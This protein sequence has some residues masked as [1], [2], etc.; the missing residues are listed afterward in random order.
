MTPTERTLVAAAALAVLLAV[1]ACES[2]P[3]GRIEGSG[4]IEV[5]E[6]RV[7]SLVGG[8]IAEVLVREGDRVSTGD[9]LLR[10]DP[11]DIDLQ[12]DQARAGLKAAEAQLAMA[13]AGA[14][15][16]DIKAAKELV[17]QASAAEAS[18]TA[19]LERVKA[20]NSQGAA[21]DKQRDDAQTRHDLAAAQKGQA[22]AQYSKAAGGAR[23]EELE[24]AEAGVE[25]ARAAVNL[26]EKKLA[27]CQVLAPL[28]GVVV[29]RLVEPGEIGGPGGTLFVI[30]DHSVVRLT[31]FIPETDLGR[32]TLGDPVAVSIDSHPDRTFPGRV[33]RIRDEA[34]FTPKN[35]Q[36]KDERVK[37]VFGIEVELDNPDGILKP[38]LPADAVIGGPAAAPVDRSAEATP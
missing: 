7:S 4:T 29:H 20:L 2:G 30:Q 26:A 1:P 36:T 21:T 8:R 27:D 16:E 11:A 15:W 14:R 24:M 37:L 9:L 18:A 12:A 28:D 10:F 5:D 13:R 6:V 19:D 32:V 38:G 25:Q 34:E 33:A 31:V 35:V 17:N 23:P 22:K 3:S